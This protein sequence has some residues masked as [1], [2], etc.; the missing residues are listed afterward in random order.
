MPISMP[1]R[2]SDAETQVRTCTITSGTPV[3]LVNLAIVT[4]RHQVQRI[5]EQMPPNVNT[6]VLS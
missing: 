1:A 5:L 2:A 4:P 6:I 3:L